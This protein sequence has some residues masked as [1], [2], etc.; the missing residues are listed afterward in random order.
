MGKAREW[1]KRKSGGEGGG[2]RWK[3]RGKVVAE[4]DGK[5]QNTVGLVVSPLPLGV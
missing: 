2:R 1:R 5:L 3:K 4:D